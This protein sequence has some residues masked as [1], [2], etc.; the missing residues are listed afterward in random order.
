MPYYA[1][2][3]GKKPGIYETWEECKAQVHGYKGAEFKKFPDRAMAISYI[4][5]GDDSDS[6]S[7]L[8]NGPKN[9]PKSALKNGPEEQSQLPQEPAPPL[10]NP[11]PE[12]LPERFSLPKWPCKSPEAVRQIP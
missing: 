10:E 1:V 3:K 11:P 4:K 12:T 5:E 6:P 8:E 2:K 9:T 7:A